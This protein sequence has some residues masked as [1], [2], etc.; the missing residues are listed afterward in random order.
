MRDFNYIDNGICYSL[1]YFFPIDQQD[2]IQINKHLIVSRDGRKDSKTKAEKNAV[3]VWW[4]WLEEAHQIN[5]LT[6]FI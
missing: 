6:S 1:F 2:F 5:F 3:S 4:A